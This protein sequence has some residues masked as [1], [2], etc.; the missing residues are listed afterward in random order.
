MK[1]KA[2]CVKQEF[3]KHDELKRAALRAAAALLNIPDA[4]KHLLLKI[5]LIV[6]YACFVTD[7][8]PHLSEFIVHVRNSAELLAVF[9]SMQKDTGYHEIHIIM[10]QS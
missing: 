8:N 1:L 6:S 4:G 9:E 2:H 10:D 3:E 5:K 7:K